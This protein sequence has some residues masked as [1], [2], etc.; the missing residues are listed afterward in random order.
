MKS[1]WI[2]G[3]IVCGAVVIGGLIALQWS[4]AQEPPN[5]V[6]TTAAPFADVQFEAQ[7]KAM[8]H[9]KRA[10]ADAKRVVADAKRFA[11][12]YVGPDSR[13]A[14]RAAAEALR[15]AE[16]EAEQT[17]TQ[18]KLNELLSQYFEQDM[19]RRQAELED[20][21]KRL[22]KLR[23]Q[24]DRR[25]A[26]KEEIID[27][28]MKVLVNEADGLGFFGNSSPWELDVF[29]VSPPFGGAPG[30]PAPR[31]IKRPPV[32]PRGEVPIEAAPPAQP[33]VAPQDAAAA[34]A[35]QPA[36]TPAAAPQ[37]ATSSDEAPAAI[38]Q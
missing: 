13:S 12:I 30:I 28:Q 21:E 37:P 26:K 34:S 6:D 20:I 16:G 11:R 17:A 18:A 19:V 23:E 33:A 14:I 36:T 3:C 2:R 25:R 8:E 32:P 10:A 22:S 35:P 31:R 4:R 15:D 38:P 5:D 7:M 9:A 1:P 24:L 29:G 27:L